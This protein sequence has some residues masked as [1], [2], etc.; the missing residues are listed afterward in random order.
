MNK[1]L[2]IKN[3]KKSYYS[4]DG[5]VLAVNDFSLSVNEG[6]FISIIGS[7]GC[8]KSTVLNVI[9]ELDSDYE[10]SIIYKNSELVKGYMLQEDCLFP[11][12]TI[13]ENALL[14]LKV[15]KC[16]NTESLE[17]TKNLLVKYGLKEFMD[18]YPSDLSG[19]MRQR[20]L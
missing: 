13:L 16:L 7:S 11:W 6:E 19:G 10:G 5:E 3:L 15:S 20:V 12:L 2:E 17:Y 4:L 18:K 8:G 9:S 1:I 14:G